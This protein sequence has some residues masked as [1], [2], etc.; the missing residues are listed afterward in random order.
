MI[1]TG[2]PY[3]AS[4]T[5]KILI[6]GSMPG[7]KSLTARQYYAHPQNAFWPIMTELFNLNNGLS[8]KERLGALCERHIALW[9]VAHHCIRPGSMDHAI[10]TDSVIAN[11]FTSL[12]KTH[13]HIAAIF[14]NG[15][16]AEE[17]F[18]KLVLPELPSS[19]QKIERCTLPSTSPA[20]ARMNLKQK[21]S[22][23]KIICNTLENS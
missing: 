2:F 1:D 21:V 3:S 16:K 20:H 19:F 22:A 4:A 6:L 5:A 7:Q 9:D 17:L 12:L 15:H 18:R 11:N 23:W 10:K 13:P 8:Y 14:F